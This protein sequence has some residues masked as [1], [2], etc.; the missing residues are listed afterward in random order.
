MV[1]KEGGFV[2]MKGGVVRTG[3]TGEIVQGQ[4]GGCVICCDS[5][6]PPSPVVPVPHLLSVVAGTPLSRYLSLPG[7]QHSSAFH[8]LFRFTPSA[9]APFKGK[10]N[11]P[12]M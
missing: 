12:I 10:T 3:I 9:A 7:T 11:L 4:A 1:E 5:F 6:A 2:W 8:S